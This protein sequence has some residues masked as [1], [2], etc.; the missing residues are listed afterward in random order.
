MDGTFLIKY[1]QCPFLRSLY[2]IQD[3][4]NRSLVRA[5]E[6]NNSTLLFLFGVSSATLQAYYPS[7]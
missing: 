7:F 4:Q 1:M 5:I 2:N 3:T 6:S